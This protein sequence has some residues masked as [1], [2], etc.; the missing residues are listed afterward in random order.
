MCAQYKAGTRTTILGGLSQPT[1]VAVGPDRALYVSN[2]GA[3]AVGPPP[4]YRG[5][6]EVLRI[7]P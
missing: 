6:G 3:A 2:H 1:S 4:D 5:V 7:V